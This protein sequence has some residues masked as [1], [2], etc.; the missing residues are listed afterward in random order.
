MQQEIFK[1][2]VSQGIWAALFVALL[3]YVLKENSRR[4]QELRQTIDNL[5]SKFEILK[6]IEEALSYLKEDVREM[7]NHVFKKGG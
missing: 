4:E 7:K 6:S 3:F 5:V 1:L 2:A